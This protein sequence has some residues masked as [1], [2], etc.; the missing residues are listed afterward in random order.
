VILLVDNFDSFTHNLA[1]LLA[2]TWK[3]PRVLRVDR[4][5]VSQVE[6]LRP[7]ALVLSPGPGRPEDAGCLNELV[8]VFAG[9]IPMLGICLGYH[10]LGEYLGARVTVS[11]PPIHG[12]TTLL[13]HSG[14]GLFRDCPQP[15]RAARYHSLRL[16]WPADPELDPGSLP[17]RV[18]E[19]LWIDGAAGNHQPMSLRSESLMLHGLQF[20]PE[21]F[22]GQAG[23]RFIGN[24]REFCR[25]RRAEYQPQM[26]ASRPACPDAAARPEIQM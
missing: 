9:R 20:H 14:K 8:A 19:D 18:G 10:A 17:A 13:S 3:E 26:F 24:F 4:I 5:S 21:S 25:S 22:L 7:E 2:V 11:D 1:H 12:K 23:D 6:M 16:N 15:L